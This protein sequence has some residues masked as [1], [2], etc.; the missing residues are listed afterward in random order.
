MTKLLFIALG[1]GLGAALRYA[2]SSGVQRLSD[3]T[4]PIGT[5]S[6]NVLGCVGIGLFGTL[7]TGPIM[8]RE[9]VRFAVL[10]GFLGG[11]TTF[12][13]FGYET[14]ALLADGEWWRAAAN[15]ILQNVLCLVAVFGGYRLAVL[16]QGV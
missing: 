16:W 14:T 15:V 10:V 5:L 1:G 11:F 12:S 4:F 3:G 7:F 2:V 8:V 6:V 13:T 9:E